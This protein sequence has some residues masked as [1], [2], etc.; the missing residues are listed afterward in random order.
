MGSLSFP[1][2]SQRP[3]G[4]LV[5]SWVTPFCQSPQTPVAPSRLNQFSSKSLI[6]LAYHRAYSRSFDR[7]SHGKD[8]SH[9]VPAQSCLINVVGNPCLSSIFYFRSL[10]HE[11]YTDVSY[12]FSS[13]RITLPPFNLRPLITLASHR[14]FAPFTRH[15]RA[16]GLFPVFRPTIT[17]QGQLTHGQS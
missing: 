11:N 10:D 5:R 15:A 4:L 16:I 3:G 12:P 13:T 17:R 9:S 2:P 1:S 6:T 8:S 14:D 7:R